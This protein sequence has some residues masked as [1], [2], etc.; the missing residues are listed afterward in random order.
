MGFLDKAKAQATA[1]MA[2]GQAKVGAMQSNRS[3]GEL[4]RALG[5]ATYAAQRRGGAADAVD[6]A[7]VALDA[8]FTQLA[9]QAAAAPPQAWQGGG[10]P[11]G[12]PPGAPQGQPYVPPPAGSPAAPPAGN[13]TLDDM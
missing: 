11:A 13:F 3:E 4:Y 9:Q 10:A 7:I 8:H 1:A 6:A 12:P 2:Q 5:E